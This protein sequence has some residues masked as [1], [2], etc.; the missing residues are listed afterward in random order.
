MPLRVPWVGFMARRSLVVESLTFS[1]AATKIGPLQRCWG[2]STLW[3][4][5][6]R[7]LMTSV[8]WVKVQTRRDAC[9][10]DSARTIWTAP[11]S[12]RSPTMT[13]ERSCDDYAAGF[14]RHP[15]TDGGSPCWSNPDAVPC[16]MQEPMHCCANK[17]GRNGSHFRPFAWAARHA[18]LH[19]SQSFCPD[20]G[21]CQM[22]CHSGPD[23]R[24]MWSFCQRILICVVV[25]KSGRVPCLRAR[26]YPS[27]PRGYLL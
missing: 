4:L 18:L 22:C 24:S 15:T 25:R 6:V 1:W 19:G 20:S 3:D 21:M 8:V 2:D 9:R 11:S 23:R 5:V 17:H 14:G 26:R 7:F 10:Q 27:R 13:A 16:L 12:A